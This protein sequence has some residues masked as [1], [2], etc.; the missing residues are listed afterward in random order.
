[1]KLWIVLK[2]VY[3]PRYFY[4]TNCNNTLNGLQAVEVGSIG[5]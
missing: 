3:L 2:P 5:H 4:S 1:M